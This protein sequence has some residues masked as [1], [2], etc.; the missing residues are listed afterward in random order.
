VNL[1]ADPIAVQ[2]ATI[3]ISNPELVPYLTTQPVPDGPGVAPG[4]SA[5]ILQGKAVPP[6]PSNSARKNSMMNEQSGRSITASTPVATAQ[7]KSVESAANSSPAPIAARASS[8]SELPSAASTGQLA[9][10][11]AVASS[12]PVGTQMASASSLTRADCSSLTSLG[13]TARCYKQLR[14]R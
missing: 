5:P 9:Q 13:E 12:A 6:V 7:A 2:G 14:G 11:S 4:Q 1:P 3:V 10:G 8:T